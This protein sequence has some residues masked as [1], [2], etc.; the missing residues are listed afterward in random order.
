MEGLAAG[1]ALETAGSDLESH[2][3]DMPVVNYWRNPSVL[4]VIHKPLE[5]ASAHRQS[6]WAIEH[7]QEVE[8]ARHMAFQR[9]TS[10]VV[11]EEVGEVEEEVPGLVVPQRRTNPALDFEPQA[12]QECVDHQPF[13]RAVAS[14]EL[15]ESDGQVS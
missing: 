14:S 15:G 9:N 3:A 12:V 2:L 10:L 11:L 7:L 8:H 1:N 5:K 6:S 13:Q 4:R